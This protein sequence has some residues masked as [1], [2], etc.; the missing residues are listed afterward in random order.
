MKVALLPLFAAEEQLVSHTTSQ[1]LQQ[2]ETTQEEVAAPGK[3]PE[4]P[5]RMDPELLYELRLRPD[6]DEQEPRD[7]DHVH[8][9]TPLTEQPPS[10]SSYSVRWLLTTF[11]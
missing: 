8:M 5:L 4:T 6:Y 9:E 1:N 2:A 7:S 11:S 3:L 10:P